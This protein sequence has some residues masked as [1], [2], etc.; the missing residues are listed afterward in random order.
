[1][2]HEVAEWM[3]DPNTSNPVPAWGHIGQQ[4]NCQNNLEVGDPLT[5][6]AFPPVTLGGVTYDLQE[7]AFYSWF[8]GGTSLGSGGLYSNNGTFKGFAKACPP[9]GTN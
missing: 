5:G 8:F 2:S 4:A 9:G 1:M 3:D 7:L 6:T